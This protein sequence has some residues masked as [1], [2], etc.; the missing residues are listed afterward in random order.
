[1]SNAITVPIAIEIHLFYQN[2]INV[3][4]KVNERETKK[5]KKLVTRL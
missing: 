3:W 4:K 1:M 2:G 5:K